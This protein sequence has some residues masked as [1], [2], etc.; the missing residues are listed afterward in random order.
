MDYLKLIIMEIELGP[1]TL[2]EIPED[3]EPRYYEYQRVFV[4][5]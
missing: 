2:T 1:A 3:Y 5:F 4:L